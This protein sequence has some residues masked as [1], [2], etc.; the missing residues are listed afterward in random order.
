MAYI[1]TLGW[2]GGSVRRMFAD[3]EANYSI[4]DSDAGG[5]PAPVYAGDGRNVSRSVASRFG[6]DARAD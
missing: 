4:D 6:G 2:K 3:Y 1:Y 5:A